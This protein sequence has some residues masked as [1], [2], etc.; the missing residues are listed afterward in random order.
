MIILI[1]GL[2]HLAP[3]LFGMIYPPHHALVLFSVKRNCS[4]G[5]A[6]GKS[7]IRMHHQVP[8]LQTEITSLLSEHNLHRAKQVVVTVEYNCAK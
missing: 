4:Q 5:V 3:Y 2:F 6:G 8:L 7:F 1:N